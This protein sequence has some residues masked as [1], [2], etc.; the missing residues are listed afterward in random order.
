MEFAEGF[1][2]AE[3]CPGAAATMGMDPLHAAHSH[4]GPTQ[5]GFLRRDVPHRGLEYPDAPPE[6]RRGF[7]E[8]T[9]LSKQPEELIRNELAVLRE[10]DEL[11]PALVFR[12]PYMLDFL[13][14]ADT[15]S[16]KD[17]EEIGVANSRSPKC[18][19]ASWVIESQAE[20]E[21]LVAGVGKFSQ[22]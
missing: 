12:D 19:S 20:R 4:Q 2:G 18:T 1:R 14:L 11:T 21:F 5:T 8:G 15:Y 9:A 16:E 7:Y 6:D 10:K 3:N 17:L 13:E 22:P